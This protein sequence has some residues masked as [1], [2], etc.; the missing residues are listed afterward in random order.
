[1]ADK[2]GQ[3]EEPQLPTDPTDEQ[4]NQYK[5]Q[6]EKYLAQVNQAVSETDP[7]VETIPKL[8][9]YLVTDPNVETDQN[10]INI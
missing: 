4:R 3:I 2:L 8:N 7:N 9:K 5:N 10:L 6:V 1:L